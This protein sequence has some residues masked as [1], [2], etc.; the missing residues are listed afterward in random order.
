M[1]FT[2]GAR[3]LP[4]ICVNITVRT[5]EWTA[6]GLLRKPISDMASDGRTAGDRTPRR[7]RY[8]IPQSTPRRAEVVAALGAALVIGHLLIAQLTGVLALLGYAITRGGR[9]HRSW[10]WAPAAIGLIWTLAIGPVHALDGWWAGPR[11][12]LDYLG[13]IGAHAERIEHLGAAY[14]G[15]GGWLPRQFPIA[16]L[17]GSAEAAFALAL[18][19]M[20]TNEWHLPRLR[21]GLVVRAR[22][23]L[24]TRG[25]RAG[26]VVS[27]DGA[28]LGVDAAT[29]RPVALRWTEAAGGVLVAGATGAGKSTTCRQMVHA[30]IRRRKPVIAV[31]LSGSPETVDAVR[32]MCASTGAPFQVFAPD[33]RTWYEPLRDAGPD[34]RA[35]M[36]AGMVDWTG[37]GEQYRRSCT[38]YLR[39]MFTVVEAA[40]GD[41]RASMLDEVVH[42]I[43][44]DALQARA[45]CIPEYHQDR[46][47]LLAR[48]RVAADTVRADPQTTA[49]LT[50]QLAELHES[51]IGRRL[52][53][54]PYAADGG[55]AGPSDREID[56]GRV[57]HGRGVVLFSLP[58]GRVAATVAGLVTADVLEL[59][60]ELRR[61]GVDGDGLVW[62]DEFDRIGTQTAVQLATRGRDAGLPMLLATASNAAATT[63]AE[64]VGAH[65]VHRI[66][67][68]DTG[69]VFAALT[70]ERVIAGPSS[71][72]DGD[73]TGYVRRPMV[74]ADDIAGLH[75]GTFALVVTAPKRRV[76][77]RVAAVRSSVIRRPTADHDQVSPSAPRPAP[78]ADRPA[79]VP[80]EGGADTGHRP[81]DEPA[82]DDP[83]GPR[84]DATVDRPAIRRRIPHQPRPR[85]NVA[86]LGD[87]GRSAADAPDLDLHDAPLPPSARPPRKNPRRS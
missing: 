63:L 26:R 62:L 2:D 52:R 83:T 30:A 48:A 11:Q 7:A 23:L 50:G 16:L 34:A 35:E 76:V 46:P 64:I 21:R 59:G 45:A 10:L 79:P 56:L 72:P 20:H 3:E 69:R 33:G 24:T 27:K 82:P 18:R 75:T 29:G 13:G 6:G 61:L 36:V 51:A 38:G 14:A 67:D 85:R 9:L 80:D 39:D 55:D 44:P 47:A 81:P 74:D 5:G 40:P 71:T 73:T 68:P 86:A 4:A 65:V 32:A 42:L 22:T 12:V 41:G 84:P 43:D 57:V 78:P 77:A 37:V 87:T 8:L 1:H 25:I 54:D 31:D 28:V 19:R 66:T 15:M 60:L 70:G 58:P 49:T 17:L 53:P